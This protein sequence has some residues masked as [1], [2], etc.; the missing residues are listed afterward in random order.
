ME[1][2]FKEIPFVKKHPENYEIHFRTNGNKVSVDI[3]SVKG[4]FLQPLVDL[5]LDWNEYQ[6]IDAYIYF[7]N[8]SIVLPPF[9]KKCQI[10][11]KNV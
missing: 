6:K 3:T 2:E 11:S 8:F 9:R 1:P 4:E 5:K 10:L 7:Y